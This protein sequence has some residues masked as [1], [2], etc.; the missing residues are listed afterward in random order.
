M[1]KDK[2]KQIKK[3]SRIVHSIPKQK[4]KQSAKIYDRKKG[5]KNDIWN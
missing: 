5:K 4:I 1:D 2:I 3:E